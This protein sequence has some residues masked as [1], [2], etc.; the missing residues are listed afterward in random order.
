LHRFPDL[1]QTIENGAPN[2]PTTVVQA[3]KI[4]EPSESVHFR[5]PPLVP[6]HFALQASKVHTRSQQRLSAPPRRPTA[7][8]L[9]EHRLEQPGKVFA[10]FLENPASRARLGL[11]R[12]R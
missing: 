9:C 6:L 3:L 10:N 5:Q 7:T 2:V 11:K 1:N 12:T 4:A 8:Q